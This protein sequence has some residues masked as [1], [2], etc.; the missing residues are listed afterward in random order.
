[1]RITMIIAGLLLSIGAFSQSNSQWVNAADSFQIRINSVTE[2][3]FNNQSLTLPDGSQLESA[4][5]V[6]LEDA[7]IDISQYAFDTIKVNNLL[8]FIRPDSAW[9]ETNTGTYL[10]TTGK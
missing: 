4:E 10:Y 1:M 7:S 9:V 3:T 5:S 6:N 2:F 8:Y